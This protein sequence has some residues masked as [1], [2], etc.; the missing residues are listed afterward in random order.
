VTAAPARALTL[1][2]LS[3]TGAIAIE[4]AGSIDIDTGGNV[5]DQITLSADHIV[6]PGAGPS[7]PDSV[8]SLSGLVDYTASF[9]EDIWIEIVA[10]SGTLSAHAATSLSVSGPLLTVDHGPCGLTGSGASVQLPG[11]RRPAGREE[12]EHRDVL[13]D[14]EEGML[15]TR[16]HIENGAGTYRLLLIADLDAAAPLD[17]VVDLVFVVRGLQVARSRGQGVDAAAQRRNAQE[18]AIGTAGG[19]SCGHLMCQIEGL[20]E[21]ILHQSNLHA[22]ADRSAAEPRPERAQ[23]AAAS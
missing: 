11:I 23:P 4:S 7:V 3:G 9:D 13:L 14:L 8:V 19:L 15:G 20:P 21:F 1:V 10:W 2:Q 22:A 5:F 18:L 6:I 16:L 12:Y 17:D